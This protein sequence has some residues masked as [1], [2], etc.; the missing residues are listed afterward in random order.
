MNTKRAAA[1]HHRRLV[2]EHLRIRH[3]RLLELI[4]RGGSLSQAA[5]ALHLSQPAVT[6]ML[7]ELEHVFGPALVER[8]AR[9]GRLTARGL[10]TLERLRLALAH[11]DAALAE[12][13]QPLPTL[14]VGLLPVAAMT[15]LP[16]A[17]RRL[18]QRAPVHLVLHEATVVGLL[19]ELLA[20]RLDCVIG[21][22]DPAW[23][24]PQRRE[25]VRST[26]LATDAL[27]VAAAPRD[28]LAR[29]RRVGLPQ[30]AERRWVLAHPG[31]ST[32]LQ[33]DDLFIRAGL[34][35]PQPQIES[36]SL[37][38]NM[39]LVAT[40]DLLTLAPASAVAVYERLG[41]VRRLRTVDAF[42]P[43]TFS[44]VTVDSG[45]GLEALDGLRDALLAE[46]GG[47]RSRRLHDA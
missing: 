42:A 1:R 3:L 41:Q 19:D 2:G 23:L 35:P 33:F 36:Q 7:H 28:P 18:Q 45:A 11:F 12:R 13:A 26:P 30:L 38:T 4:E 31:S 25:H 37:H 17:L 8:G 14:R 47:G 6:K 39:Q 5:L 20:G 32:R 40:S 46:V 22:V 24:T 16:G 34:T 29:A 15:L 27:A 10:A 44:F 9:G 21:P 43:G